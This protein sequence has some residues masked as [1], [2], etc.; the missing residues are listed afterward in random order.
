MAALILTGERHMFNPHPY[1]G[2]PTQSASILPGVRELFSGEAWYTQV[3]KPQ[4][5]VN[6]TSDKKHPIFAEQRSTKLQLADLSLT[7]NDKL[8]SPP[9]YS[10]LLHHQDNRRSSISSNSLSDSS[11]PENKPTS[12]QRNYVSKRHVCH[13]CHKRFPRPSSLRIHLHTHTGEKPYECEYPGCRRRFSVLSNLR[14]H[15]KTH[16]V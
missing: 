12:G 9:G 3:N 7:A 8:H 6:N 1:S 11:V 16:P 5:D 13:V 4:N 14:R 2:T 10:A 15:Q